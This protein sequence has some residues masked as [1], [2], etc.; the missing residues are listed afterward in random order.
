MVRPLEPD[1]PRRI[2]MIVEV[3]KK[4]EYYR[5]KTEALVSFDKKLT[6]TSFLLGGIIICLGFFYLITNN[7]LVG[8]MLYSL[9]G[10]V[11]ITIYLSNC[12]ETHIL[13]N[14]KCWHN[15]DDQVQ[16]L[17]YERSEIPY[18]TDE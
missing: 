16:A 4:A 15:H 5:G 12:I 17:W 6:K 9:L 7:T 14:Q 10:A 11:T 13:I 18:T 3:E 2:D 8:T 1:D